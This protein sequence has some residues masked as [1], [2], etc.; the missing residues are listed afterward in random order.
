MLRRYFDARKHSRLGLN[1]E[2][3]Q[4]HANASVPWPAPQALLS[5]AQI[6]S[7]LACGRPIIRSTFA[8]F[9]FVR[10][11]RPKRTPCRVFEG[12]SEGF[13]DRR[14][15]ELAGEDVEAAGQVL[16]LLQRIQAL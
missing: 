14:V 7:D 6:Q 1:R 16:V 13:G 9:A 8:S 5:E 12:F 3:T 11:S 15:G 4:M 2:R 10:G